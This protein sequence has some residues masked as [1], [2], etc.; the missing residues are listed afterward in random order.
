M[1]TYVDY[2]RS[3]LMV[4]NLD[5]LKGCINILPDRKPPVAALT[6]VNN[7]SDRKCIEREIS[8]HLNFVFW[9]FLVAIT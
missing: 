2:K 3:L 1:L 9:F 8:A 7:L 5:V 4:Q 6:F